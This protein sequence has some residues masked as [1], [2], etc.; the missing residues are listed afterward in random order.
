MGN[1][2]DWPAARLVGGTFGT[3]NGGSVLT[4][5]MVEAVVP[6]FVTVKETCSDLLIA[7]D[8]KT[9]APVPTGSP[10]P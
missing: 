7:M 3:E 10:E 2:S 9:T 1:D 5:E 8:G 4:S 6:E